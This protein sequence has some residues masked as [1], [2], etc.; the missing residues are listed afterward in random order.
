VVLVLG[1][2]WYAQRSVEWVARAT[3]DGDVGGQSLALD[4]DLEA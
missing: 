4:T 1:A 3:G 2:G